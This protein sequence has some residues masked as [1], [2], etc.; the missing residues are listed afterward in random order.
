MELLGEH[1]CE[2]ENDE[3]KAV[4]VVQ[5]CEALGGGGTMVAMEL[6]PV[7]HGERERERGER[8][9]GERANAWEPMSWR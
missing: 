7:A 1:V 8:R 5:G 6:G 4:M 3:A 2:V 9:G